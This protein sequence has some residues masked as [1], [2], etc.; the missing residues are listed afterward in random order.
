[1]LTPDYV[2]L[3]T[4]TFVTLE[5]IAASYDPSFNIYTTALPITL[6]R[7]VSPSTKEARTNLRNN[8]LTETGELKL[9][10]TGALGGFFHEKMGMFRVI[11]SNLPCSNVER[12]M[13]WWRS[14][15]N[16]G[17]DDL[18]WAVANITIWRKF[19]KHNRAM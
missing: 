9:S 16:M 7:L 11:S 1:M 6:R 18:K 12:W 13:R 8:V 2:V 4:R 19:I 17:S 14:H 3:M 10:S 15:G 5:G